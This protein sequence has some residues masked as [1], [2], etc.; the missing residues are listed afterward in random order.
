MR[1]VVTGA[2]GHL[3]REVVAHLLAQGMVVSGVD[4][5]IDRKAQI[6]QTRVAD[7]EK[8]LPR[9][10]RRVGAPVDTNLYKWV[11]Y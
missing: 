9:R 3:G 5:E 7:T 4:K 6:P 1:V 10:G 8:L 2:S 11:C